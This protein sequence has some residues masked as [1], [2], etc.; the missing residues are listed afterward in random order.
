[1]YKTQHIESKG[2]ELKVIPIPVTQV[3]YGKQR[4]K[5]L[6]NEPYS[7]ISLIG[8]KKSGKTSVIFKILKDCASS[9]T[10]VIVFGSTVNKDSS[11]LYIQKY[12]EEKDIKI[13]PYVSIADDEDKKED[14]LQK[15][16]H[17][18]RNEPPSKS[19]SGELDYLLIF[20]DIGDELRHPS[21][22][23]LLKTN[24]H[25]KMKVILSTHYFVDLMPAARRQID[26][27]ILFGGLT[28]NDLETIF[29]DSN[30][31]RPWKLATFQ[32]I[33]T[34]ATVNPHSFL[35]LKNGGDDTRINFDR[36]VI[37]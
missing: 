37:I 34:D 35:Y 33:Y 25:Y 9:G 32:R 6:F 31:P 2:N 24:R 3:G 17:F 15:L 28:Q 5:K 29:K 20:D 19:E 1:M 12:C 22:N 7:N 14:H 36:E 4:G 13:I 27:W 8:R 18:L 26:Y 11:W 23:Q 21:I 16:L 10:V 30:L